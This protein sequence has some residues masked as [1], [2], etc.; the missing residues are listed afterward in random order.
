MR[1]NVRAKKTEERREQVNTPYS[2]IYFL[3]QSRLSKR[4]KHPEREE[5]EYYVTDLVRCPLKRE[6]EERYP[7]LVERFIIHP[8]FVIGDLVHEILEN[9]VTL[10][11][12]FFETEVSKQKELKIQDEIY[13]ISGRID[14]LRGNRGIELKVSRTDEGIPHQHHI[15]QCRAYNWLFDLEGTLLVYI[16]FDRLAEFWISDRMTD[17]EV[18]ERIQ[19]TLAPRYSWEC[20]Y[21]PFAVV[22]SNKRKS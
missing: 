10:Y 7:E 18:K 17:D 9:K 20:K 19:S 8:P 15:D 11:D 5:N 21:C 6:Y 2:F 1:E 12:D 3:Y 22:C 13:V 4:L 16:T 14:I